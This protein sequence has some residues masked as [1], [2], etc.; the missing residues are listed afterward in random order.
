VAVKLIVGSDTGS[1]KPEKHAVQFAAQ[2]YSY[3]RPTNYRVTVLKPKIDRLSI[4]LNIADTTKRKII[5]QHLIDMA[6]SGNPLLTMWKKFKGWGSGKYDRSFA[7]KVSNGKSILV[8]CA[9]IK[10]AVSFLRFEFNPAAIGPGGV[11][12]FRDHLLAINGGALTYKKLAHS[13]KVTRLDIAVDL[14]N[15]DLEDLLISTAKP[16][17]SQSYFGLTGKAETKY[18]NVNKK[19]SNLYVYDRKTLLQKQKAEGKGSGSE[20]GQAKYTRVEVRAE[21]NLPIAKLS[22][23]KNRLKKIALIDIEAAKPPEEEHHWKLFQDSCRYRGLAG[24]LVRLPNNVR[25]KYEAAIASA[26]TGFWNPELLWSFWPEV[27]SSS[28]LAEMGSDQ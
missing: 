6:D 12:A 3:K 20:F 17:I 18:L 10:S 2:A 15:I 24:A 28:G 25:Q 4:T 7:L 9:P 26:E 22:K 14:V 19:G 16:G 11:A 13:G 21:P 5:R 1:N 8:Q 23:L 27:L